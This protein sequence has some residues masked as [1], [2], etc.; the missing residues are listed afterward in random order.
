MLWKGT[1]GEKSSSRCNMGAKP[2][3]PV[4]PGPGTRMAATPGEY[5]SLFDDQLRCLW[6]RHAD[7][8]L[9]IGKLESVCPYGIITRRAPEECSQ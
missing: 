4:T 1:P 3:R 9:A 7:S 6:R 8:R 5:K 2:C